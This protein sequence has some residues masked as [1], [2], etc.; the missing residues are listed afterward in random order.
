MIRC[1]WT[2]ACHHAVVDT[3]TNNVSLLQ[4]ID[5]ITVKRLLERGEAIALPFE[6]MTIWERGKEGESEAAVIR[7]VL[8]SPDG[9]ELG[10]TE[11]PVD[12]TQHQRSRARL[13]V[14]GLPFHGY[15]RYRLRVDLRE[16]GDWVAVGGTDLDI[17][18]GTAQTTPGL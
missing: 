6:L 10:S 11:V 13:M 12:L 14:A 2:I 5:Q 16:D 7:F 18:D 1:R 3:Y 9:N 8:E 15:G 17:V 4:I